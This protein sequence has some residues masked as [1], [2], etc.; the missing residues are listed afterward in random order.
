MTQYKTNKKL[1]CVEHPVTLFLDDYNRSI[2]EQMQIELQEQIDM[3]LSTCNKEFPVINIFVSGS[4]G[5]FISAWILSRSVI[6]AKVTVVYI[7]KD[8]ENSHH[9]SS[10]D[11][12]SDMNDQ[13]NVIIDDFVCSGTTLR[14]ILHKARS[15]GVYDVDLLL[16]SASVKECEIPNCIKTV[17]CYK[18]S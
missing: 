16:V 2:L 6:P 4:S 17:I 13:F 7:K 3:Y 18:V 9:D 8:G 5:A 10:V 15:K 14:R 11:I 12:N 1:H